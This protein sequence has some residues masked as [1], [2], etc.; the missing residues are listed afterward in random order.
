MKRRLSSLVLIGIAA[1]LT[2]GFPASLR[3]Q[4]DGGGEPFTSFA[5]QA[6]SN[7]VVVGQYVSLTVTPTGN[8]GTPTGSVE[9]YVSSSSNTCTYSTLIGT[10]A[11]SEGTYILN[12]YA[13][14]TGTIP[15]CAAYIPSDGDAYAAAT[16]PV[17]LLSVVISASFTTFSIQ[18]YPNPVNLGQATTLTATI[19]G[20]SGAPAGQ[21]EFYVSSGTDGCSISSVIGT[22]TGS[23]GVYTESYTPSQVGS[24]SICAQYIP[25]DGDVYPSATAGIY[26]LNVAGTAPFT[27]FD[28]GASPNPIPDGF[29]ST[30][31]AYLVGNYGVPTGQVEFYSSNSATACSEGYFFGEV[32]VS[33]SGVA[34]LNTSFYNAGTWYI[35]AQYVPGQN[36][37]YASATA[38]IYLVNVMQPTLFTVSVPAAVLQGSQIPFTFGI[39]TPYG[40]VPPTG[41]ITLEDPNNDYAVIGTTTV[42]NGVVSPPTITA[43]LTGN[44]YYAV[45]SGDNN[46]ESQSVYGT[47]LY[48]NALSAISP[49]AVTVGSPTTNFTLTGAGFNANSVVYLGSGDGQVTLPVNSFT[50]TQI[51]TTITA[52]NLLIAGELSISVVTGPITGGPIT[53]QVYAPYTDTAGVSTANPTSIPY[54]YTIS[55]NFNGTVTRGV[56]ATDAAVPAG[57][58]T[59]SLT[60]TGAQSGYS[61]TLGTAALAQ[62]TTPGTYLSPFTEPID[63]NGSAKLISADLNGDGYADVIGMP[64]IYY[65]NANY[66]DYA[67]GPYL[68]VMLST[69]ADGLQTEQQVFTGCLAQDFAVGDINGDG[70]P[71]LVVVC[72]SN[73]IASGPLNNLLAY[74]MLGNGDG[75][76]QAPVQFGNNSGINYPTNIALGQ[77]NGDGYLDIAVI[78]GADGYLQV[79][80]PFQNSYGPYSYFDTSNGSVQTAGA[81]DFNQDGLS[82]IVLEEYNYPYNYNQYSNGAVLVLISQ[83]DYNGFYVLS[84]TQFT[85]T[86]YWMQSMTISDVNG[87]GYPDVAIADFGQ[88]YSDGSDNGNI[89]IFEN[90]QQGE[91]PLT[92]TYSGNNDGALSFAGAVV[93]IPFP[94]IGQPASGA[95][96]AQGWNLAYSGFGSDNN[97]W[98]QELQRQSAQNWTIVSSF[99]TLNGTYNTEGGPIPGLLVTGDMNGDGYLDFVTNAFV[100]IGD[101]NQDTWILQPWYYSNDAQ[102]TTTGSS[103]STPPLPGTYTLSMTYPGNQLYQPNPLG[104]NPAVN[105]QITI[106]EATPTG[107]LAVSPT[108]TGSP[109]AYPYGTPLTFTATVIGVTNG[110]APGGTVTFYDNDGTLGTGNLSSDGGCFSTAT[111]T[112]TQLQPG[113]NNISVS[114][115]GDPNNNYTQASPLAG[116]T[117]QINPASATLALTSSTVSTTAGAMVNFQVQA[118][119]IAV[120]PSVTLTGLPT[121]QPITL[122]LNSFGPTS[123][124]YGLF[125]PGTYTIQASLAASGSFTA[126][127]SNSVTLQVAPT[128]VNITLTPSANPVT[129][130]TSIGL[131]ANATTNG[132]GVPSGTIVFQDSGSQIG[133]G[134]LATIGGSS[135]LL[136]VGTTDTVTGQTVIA[137][138]TG[139]FNGDKNQDLAVLESGNGAASLL[140]SLGN[141][142][143]TF[144]APTTYSSAGFGFDPTTVAI[145]AADFNG[146]GYTDLVVAASDGTVVVLLGSATGALTPSQ[147]L[148]VPGAIAVATGNF[149][150]SGQGF[151]VISPTQLVVFYNNGSGNFPVEGSWSETSTGSQ[152]TGITVADFDHDGNPDIA[153]SDNSGPDAA[154]FLYVVESGIFSGPQIYPAGAS[155]TAIAS[156][157]V[158]GDGYPDLAVLSN[159]DS[160]VLVMIN[161]GPGNGGTLNSAGASYG[162]AYQPT[163]IVM[164]DF[165]KDGDT[166]IAVTGTGTP[167]GGFTNNIGTTILLGSATGAMVGEASLPSALGQAIATA[168]F[169]NDGNPD[170]AV[171][172]IGVTTFLDSAAQAGMTNVALDAGTAPLTAVYNGS[173]SGQFA[174]STSPIVNEVVNQAQPVISWSSPVGI[175]YGTP[176]GNTQLNATT[177]VPGTL[178]YSPTSGTVLS[179]GPQELT[180]T[181][182][183]FDTVD[184][185]GATAQVPITV[186]QAGTTVSWSNP[187][188]ITYGTP[189]S[190]TQLN[191]T[192]SVPGT[193]VYSPAAGTVLSGGLQTLKVT[194]TP[195]DATDY[196]GSTGTAQIQINPATPV[197]T[198]AAPAAI[199]YGTALGASQLNASASTLGTL[200]YSPVT[201]T[202]L[203]AGPHT[204]TVSFA[205]DNPA[206]YTTASGSVPIQVN[207]ATPT[208][209]WSAPA[210][211]AY[212]TPLSATQLNATATPAGGA[213]VYNPPVGAILPV[214][215]QT[216][217]VIY[218]PPDTTDYTTASATV[219]VL[220]TANLGLTSIQP[221]SATYGSQATTITLLG[222][223]FAPTSVVQLNG[224][225]IPSSYFSPDQM[226]AQIPASFFQQTQA[227]AITVSNPG[228]EL[229][230]PPVTFTVNLPSIQVEF[231]GGGTQGPG[232][233]P[234]LNLQFL[235]GYP[236]P[237]QVTLTLSVAPATSGG[238][239]DPAVQFSTG[240]DTLSFALPANSTTVPA[241]QL[242][243]GTLPG[244]IT[245][246]LTL[247]SGDQDV[248]PTGLQPVVVTVPT[249]VPVITSATLTESGNTL[250]VTVQGYSSS[251]N[252]TSAVFDF[253]PVAGATI[254]TKSV[255]VD[256]STDFST[257]YTLP[258][259]NQY[260]SAF[261]YTQVFTTSTPASSVASV[262]VTLTNSVGSSN[263]VSAN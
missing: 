116:V 53:L 153:L 79:I 82:D 34:T 178:T 75:T 233:Q 211:I 81:A 182:V 224:T 135:G 191:A 261:T 251:Q 201:G 235:A 205:P 86:T 208:V 27:V 72:T 96:A 43:T 133:S 214:G 169:N 210:S 56:P 65:P 194:F 106:T 190:T 174:A 168:D 136:S 23:N 180:V 259:M 51:Q 102:A 241:I 162:V 151:A 93:G 60:G 68:Q 3:A 124:N 175:T 31:T 110:V 108:G 84:E 140:I 212:G 99:D 215:T 30:L 39:T 167:E 246:T 163:G 164:A 187:A 152:Y 9:F 46:Y 112:T 67:A 160:T 247:E 63:T 226:T 248:T 138:V 219:S 200:T 227:G 198:W 22:T 229:T 252:M 87:D 257:W 55:T 126:T 172:L 228:S 45:Y 25:T 90:D 181:F 83:G 256:V 32:P 109:A 40:Q 61:A 115:N 24:F 41:T 58:V 98:V 192:A 249:A 103:L 15:I 206:N 213:F 231:S 195:A 244:T 49:A 245:V 220:V 203:G 143:G 119:G 7:P 142:D 10:T 50:P 114:Y 223:G 37:P 141:G 158:N 250:T 186:S 76:F 85:A 149:S 240:G 78:D 236:L 218:T 145:A 129:Y 1:I 166:D 88:Y 189:L 21:V 239:V 230:T 262:T 179:A 147:Q 253:S 242:Q 146:D 263:T 185:L 232:Q 188:A 225:T 170:L 260:G 234:T 54:G 16:T 69:G 120:P 221:S 243:T 165:N 144:Q 44:S 222:T 47:V 217:S 238:P 237:L 38:G 127:T 77:F 48:E 159:V 183:P 89:L 33:A 197:I 177:T 148:T 13:S 64:G 94:T 161:N 131:T 2:A 17:Y 122:A 196:I 157:D 11:G 118:S 19:T 14:Q 59:F 113:I 204:L 134:N 137:I 254:N 176:L 8:Y 123:F 171:G 139:D 199:T 29:M 92:F 18:A 184:Y 71:D 117:I 207:Q 193:Y 101:C 57:Q 4:T 66:G 105:T 154:V 5:I 104:S 132:L 128:P 255:T 95:A 156:G 6:S 70:I 100:C 202:V 74:Y 35:C 216:L 73:G 28:I 130:P 91:L 121:A 62:V 155:A 97:I 125:T 52:N 258:N 26:T 36:D 42:S 209:S 111:F 173:D 80:S 12:Y 107:N 150:G 20:N